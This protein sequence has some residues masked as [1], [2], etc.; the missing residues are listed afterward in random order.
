M[1]NICPI[2]NET[3]DE[4]NIRIVS[5]LT[6]ILVIVG[7]FFSYWT[8]LFLA[9]DF[10]LRIFCRN[11]SPLKK[12][13]QI[14]TKIF[15]IKKG[16]LI[17]AAP[18]KFSAGIGFIFSKIIFWLLFLNFIFIAKIFIIIFLIAVSLETFF[19]YCLGCKIYSFLQI[20]KK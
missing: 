20:L 15:K 19:N 17:D 2:S 12:I 7:Y 8:F 16:K 6:L 11:F 18:K 4:K 3:V 10:L 13:S 1:I 9:I 5:F 14:L